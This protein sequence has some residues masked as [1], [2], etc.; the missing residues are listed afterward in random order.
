M[1]KDEFV[2]PIAFLEKYVHNTTSAEER[3]HEWEEE[4]LKQAP[5]SIVIASVL[6]AISVFIL[7]LGKK[8]TK[9]TLF[10]TSALS[11]MAGSFILVDAIVG[12]VP[13][14]SAQLACGIN[15]G[16]PI[17]LGLIAG[18]IS[19]CVFQ[20]GIALLGA[21]A[22]AGAGYFCYL[23]GLHRIPSP[24]V[25]S[26]DVVFIATLATFALLGSVLMCKF[27]KTLMIVATSAVGAAGATTATAWLLAHKWPKFI[28]LYTIRDVHELS[29]PYVWSQALYCV[30]LF[31]LGLLVQCRL[32][33]RA[34]SREEERRAKI[35]IAPASLRAAA[36]PLVGI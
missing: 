9:P 5:S 27:Q 26:F 36:E 14:V 25:G 21:G 12:S 22:G 20:L 19:L 35:E 16:V 8:L 15:M 10:L 33:R 18:F 31:C 3:I 6:L 30:G 24:V 23:A 29:S 13:D 28:T 32:E 11:A 7:F 34:A 17:V 2:C 4:L 1:G